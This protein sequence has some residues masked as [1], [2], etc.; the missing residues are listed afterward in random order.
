MYRETSPFVVNSARTQAKPFIDGIGYHNTQW[1]PPWLQ[2]F[3]AIKESL[4]VS[5]WNERNEKN[6]QTT[7]YVTTSIQSCSLCSKFCFNHLD[8]QH[9][10]SIGSISSI[11]SQGALPQ[12]GPPTT[13]TILQG[14]PKKITLLKFILGPVRTS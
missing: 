4:W 9:L 6:S 2:S 7:F 1:G 11:P 5:S 3:T 12:S 10:K 14:V 13:P 8:A